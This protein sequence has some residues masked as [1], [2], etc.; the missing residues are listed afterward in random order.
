MKKLLMRKLRVSFWPGLKLNFQVKITRNPYPGLF[1]M[2]DTLKF[3]ALEICFK[4]V[5]KAVGLKLYPAID[6][7]NIFAKNYFYAT[8]G[9]NFPVAYF[10]L[11]IATKLFRGKEVEND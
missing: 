7:Q 3:V 10:I 6:I 1:E 4:V 11:F 2:I 5:S 8:I 9:K